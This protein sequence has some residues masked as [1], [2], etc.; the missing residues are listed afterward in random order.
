MPISVNST[1][2]NFADNFSFANFEVIKTQFI[3][4]KSF[5]IVKLI[6][7]IANREKRDCAADITAKTNFRSNKFPAK[8][9]IST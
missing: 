4:I 8:P 6:K 9:K 7:T 5:S 2:E 3:Q 1:K